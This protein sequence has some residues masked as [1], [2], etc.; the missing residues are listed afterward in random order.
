MSQSITCNECGG[1]IQ[2][3]SHNFW[4]RHGGEW[5][6]AGLGKREPR[7]I[8]ITGMWMNVDKPLG[9]GPPEYTTEKFGLIEGAGI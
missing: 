7:S 9:Y 8:H 4:G 1:D 5:H 3:G 6:P 2:T